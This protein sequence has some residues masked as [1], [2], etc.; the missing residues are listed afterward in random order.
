[1]DS[2]EKHYSIDP[3]KGTKMDGCPYSLFEDGHDVREYIIPPKGYVLTDFRFEPLPFNQIYDGKLVA[4]YEKVSI[5]D[6]LTSN[7]WKALIP[8]SMTTVL[9]LIVLLAVSVFNKTQPVSKEP[10]KRGQRQPI[11]A[12]DSTKR[13]TKLPPKPVE[14]PKPETTQEPIA[15]VTNPAPTTVTP[16]PEQTTVVPEQTKQPETV[17]QQPEQTVAQE[18][19][20]TQQTDADEPT[21]KFNNEFWALVHTRDHKMDSYHNLYV[22]NKK[23][24]KGD[25]YDYLRTIILR[26]YATFKQWYAKLKN[27]PDSQLQ[28]I[29]TIT[30]LR[31]AIPIS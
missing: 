28:D 1:M 23:K 24:V 15:A 22:D 9:S 12:V 18:Q 21:V 30:E 25:E 17:Q 11:A 2:I 20:P 27:I 14:K 8:I 5:H 10:P 7:L 13:K 29:N 31:R 19:S 26:D 16:T 3:G 6:R 4:Q